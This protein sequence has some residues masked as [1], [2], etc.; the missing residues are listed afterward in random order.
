MAIGRRRGRILAFQALYAWDVGAL[1][2]TDLLQFQWT[3]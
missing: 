1:P 2:P 3:H